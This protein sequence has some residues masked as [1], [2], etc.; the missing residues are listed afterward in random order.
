MEIS[1]TQ[2]TKPLTGMQKKERINEV[3]PPS[4]NLVISS[5]SEK[6][7]LWVDMLKAMPDIRVEKV[8]ANR[9]APSSIELAQ[10]I[11]LSK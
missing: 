1:E 6:K 11:I 5:E 7:A 10:K 2:S 4:D 9:F 3:K 8:E